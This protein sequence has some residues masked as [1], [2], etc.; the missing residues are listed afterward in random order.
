MKHSEQLAELCKAGSTA[1]Q[2]KKLSNTMATSKTI[3]GSLLIMHLRNNLKRITEETQD[4]ASQQLL[5]KIID[6]AESEI[7][8]NRAMFEAAEGTRHKFA[9]P[10]KKLTIQEPKKS[11]V[12]L[13]N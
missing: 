13:P 9:E 1:T 11:E 2:I 10:H 6:D 8:I 7:E 5:L 3:L 12:N 4:I